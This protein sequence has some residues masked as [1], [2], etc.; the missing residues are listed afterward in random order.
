M[1]AVPIPS[2]VPI[3]RA[4]WGQPM[5]SELSQAAGAIGQIQSPV[6]QANNIQD[7]LAK[8]NALTGQTAQELTDTQQKQYGMQASLLAGLAKLPPDQYAQAAQHIIPIANQLGTRQFDP[9]ID[10][11]TAGLIAAGGVSAPEQATL[12]NNLQRAQ[13]LNTLKA[14][15]VVTD[16]NTGQKVVIDKMTGQQRPVTPQENEYYNATGQLPSQGG[17]TPG[18]PQNGSG[19]LFSPPQ[20]QQQSSASQQLPTTMQQPQQQSPFGFNLSDTNP[21]ENKKN[22]TLTQQWQQAD[23]ANRPLFENMQDKI[24]AMRLQIPKIEGGSALSNLAVNAGRI[25]G[26]DRAQA[27]QELNSQANDLATMATQLQGAKTGSR[28]SVLQLKTALASKPNSTN[29]P[30][31]NND[32]LDE[33]EGKV[34]RADA[35]SSLYN[36]YIQANPHK[37]LDNNANKLADALDK[38]FPILD[39]NGKLNPDNLAQW[40]AAIPDAIQNPKQYLNAK[41]ELPANMQ[42]QGGTNATQSQLNAAEQADSLTAAKQAIANGAPRDA[43]IQR[44]TGAGIP[45]SLLGGL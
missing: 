35:D 24:A 20:Q 37:T 45:K 18:M 15:D 23:Q 39:K 16:P 7:Q 41:S 6:L 43:V 32:L 11:Q 33:M 30:N 13:M 38:Q 10:Q 21:L 22:L 3:E 28:G 44:L 17:T 26:T 27:A 1:P 5:G 19:M 36:A 12:A 31:V 2:Q 14:Q 4:S 25:V 34:A 9:T 40:K 42:Q 29:Y 8:Q